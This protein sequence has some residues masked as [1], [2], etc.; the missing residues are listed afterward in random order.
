M[1][2]LIDSIRTQLAAWTRRQNPESVDERARN[3]KAQEVARLT[4]VPLKVDGWNGWKTR[5]WVRMFQASFCLG[6]YWDSPLRPSGIVDQSTYEALLACEQSGG[7]V[8]DDFYYSE[9][10]TRLG[11]GDG[12]RPTDV[13]TT[14]HVIR[15]TRDAAR[16]AQTIRNGIGRP[17]VLSSA[18]R[19]DWWN[20]IVGGAR[21]SQHRKGNGFD[22]AA[23][24]QLSPEFLRGCGAT[25]IGIDWKTKVGTHADTRNGL[26]GRLVTWW[27][28]APAGAAPYVFSELS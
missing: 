27:Y 19:D 21:L 5:R 26:F 13:T 24:Y 12:Y 28:G 16:L 8:S 15:V 22:F 7:K 14:N 3:R 17:F 11:Q 20:T 25:G 1:T 23:G 4:G 2:P 18:Y 9:W 10:R 6:D